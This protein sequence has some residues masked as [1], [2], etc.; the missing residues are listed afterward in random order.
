MCLGSSVAAS[1]SGNKKKKE[2]RYLL[3]FLTIILAFVRKL[4]KGFY[5]LYCYHIGTK[6]LDSQLSDQ[7]NSAFRFL[8]QHQNRAPHL[9]YYKL[10]IH[11][12]LNFVAF[13]GEEEQCTRSILEIIYICINDFISHYSNIVQ[14]ENK[15]L[16][17]QRLTYYAVRV[18]VRLELH[19]QFFSENAGFIFA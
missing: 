2:A 19:I 4:L 11:K 3:L 7:S 9:V 17:N 10:F 1:S 14:K 13:H 12:N 18:V 15:N 6:H 5:L 16:K 8:Y